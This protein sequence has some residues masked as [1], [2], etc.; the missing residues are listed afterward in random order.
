MVVPNRV[1]SLKRKDLLSLFQAIAA[2]YDKLLNPL[3]L[4]QKPRMKSAVTVAAACFGKEWC[5]PGASS[6]FGGS[7]LRRSW[8]LLWVLAART[9]TELRS[10]LY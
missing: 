1:R 2:A 8:I 3:G 10:K 4:G 9:C 6:L 5:G 7:I